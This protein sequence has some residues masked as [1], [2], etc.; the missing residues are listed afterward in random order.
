MSI[1]DNAESFITALVP[2]Q[3]S[4]DNETQ[5]QE[6]SWIDKGSVSQALRKTLEYTKAHF[7]PPRLMIP[8]MPEL[9]CD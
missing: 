6:S 7:S 2:G 1:K 3:R 9:A 5:Q 8:A 4:T